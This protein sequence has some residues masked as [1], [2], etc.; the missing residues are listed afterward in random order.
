MRDQ[1][2]QL[3]HRSLWS[4]LITITLTKG[5]LLIFLLARGK[6]LLHVTGLNRQP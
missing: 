5:A 2:Q 4:L 1:H 6:K 3:S